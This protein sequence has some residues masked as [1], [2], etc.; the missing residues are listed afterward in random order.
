MKLLNPE[1]LEKKN[2]CKYEKEGCLSFPDV[3]INTWRYNNIKIK[4]DFNGEQDFSG[5][6]AVIIQ[7]EIDHMDGKLF[8]D[9]KTETFKRTEA[10]IGRNDPCPCKS[11]KKYKKCCLK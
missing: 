1:I 2:L 8:F 9:V 5:I 11:G 10:K 6:M 3:F 4:D 7:H